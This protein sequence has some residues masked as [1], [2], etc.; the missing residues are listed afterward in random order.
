MPLESIVLPVLFAAA[1]HMT[2]V[3]TANKTT[4]QTSC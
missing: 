3:D 2:N 1:E 4:V